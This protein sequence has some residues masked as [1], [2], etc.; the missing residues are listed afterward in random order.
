LGMGFEQY[1]NHLGLFGEFKFRFG[2][3]YPADPFGIV[4]VGITLGAKFN[5][6]SIGGTTKADASGKPRNKRHRIASKQYHLF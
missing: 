2:K 1:F 6:L 5:L 4:D 3:N